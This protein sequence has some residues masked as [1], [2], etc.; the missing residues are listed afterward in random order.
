MA[1]WR[2]DLRTIFLKISMKDLQ[3]FEVHILGIIITHN[4]ILFIYYKF[5]SVSVN[6]MRQT[7]FHCQIMR[8]GA[9]IPEIWSTP[10][11]FFE[12][13]G[14]YISRFAQ[15]SF[16]VCNPNQ[17]HWYMFRCK[18]NTWYVCLPKCVISLQPTYQYTKWTKQRCI[19]WTGEIEI[20]KLSYCFSWV[21]SN[22]KFFVYSIV[23]WPY[24]DN[25]SWNTYL[26]LVAKCLLFR[27]S[28]NVPLFK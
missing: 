22:R 27:R 8:L 3:V 19:L 14:K 7:A 18:L 17:N 11:V 25:N 13:R 16:S 24:I 1:L 26:L 20:M 6:Q 28:C 9:A 23:S 4:S 12:Q 15:K 2:C 5:K 10:P 21:A